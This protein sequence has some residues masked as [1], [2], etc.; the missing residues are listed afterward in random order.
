ML[1]IDPDELRDQLPGYNGR[2]SS[3]FQPAVSVVVE[4]LHDLALSGSLSFI[5]DGTLSKFGKAKKNIDRSLKRGRSVQ[6]LYVY[7]SPFTAWEFVQAREKEEGRGIPVESFISQ[8]FEARDTVNRLKLE[9]GQ[10]IKVAVLFKDYASGNRL[11]KAGVDDINYH[12]PE[13]FTRVQL[14]AALRVV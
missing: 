10:K 12:I 4:K 14:E 5:L 2:N 8:Y 3:L 1:R 6:I 13:Q 9:L 7:Q 11:Y